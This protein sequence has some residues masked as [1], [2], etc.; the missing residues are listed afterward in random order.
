[1]H[2]CDLLASPYVSPRTTDHCPLPLCRWWR[3]VKSRTKDFLRGRAVEDKNAWEEELFL[4]HQDVAELRAKKMML[5]ILDD[6]QAQID[7]GTIERNTSGCAAEA[8]LKRLRLETETL[9]AEHSPQ[10][11]AAEADANRQQQAKMVVENISS[12]RSMSDHS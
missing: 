7:E 1:M 5:A 9:S 12:P 3:A 8:V 11:G 10:S 2:A 6:I 4:E